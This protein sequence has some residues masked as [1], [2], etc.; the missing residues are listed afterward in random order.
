MMKILAGLLVAGG[1][2]GAHAENISFE[3][4]KVGEAPTGWTCGS[5]GG[6]APRWTVEVDPAGPGVSHVL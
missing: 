5:T 1:A 3:G 4:D 2:V 6:G